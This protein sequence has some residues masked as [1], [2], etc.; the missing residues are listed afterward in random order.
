[1]VDASSVISRFE[2]GLPR[3]LQN[4]IMGEETMTILM[5]CAIGLGAVVFVVGMMALFI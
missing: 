1:L 5:N 2:E 4:I 3:K